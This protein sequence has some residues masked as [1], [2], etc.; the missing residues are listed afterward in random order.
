MLPPLPLT[1]APHGEAQGGVQTD[2][3]PQAPHGEVQGGVQTEIQGSD[4]DI[5]N[6]TP[7]EMVSGEP[8]D[9]VS[10]FEPRGPSAIVVCS[11]VYQY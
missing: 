4:G 9:L 3:R 10:G 8:P 11:V 2:Q 6:P 5:E 7:P 1:Q